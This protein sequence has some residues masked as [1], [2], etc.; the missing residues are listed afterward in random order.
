MADLL[1]A[2]LCLPPRPLRNADDLRLPPGTCDSHLH[3]F[4]AGAPLASPRNYTPQIETLS[5]WLALAGSFG[6][7]RGVLVQPSVY[8]LDN[9]VLLTALTAEPGR[10]RG[11][12]VIAPDTGDAE[13]RRLDRLGVRGVRINLRNKAGLGL[14]AMAALAPCISKLGWHVQFQVGPDA[15]GTVAELCARHAIDGVIDHLAFMPLDPPGPALD[16]L[17]RALDGGRV[18]AKISAPYRLEDTAGHAGYR[19]ALAVLAARHPDRLLWG[20]DWPHTELF[21]SMPEDHA[22]VALSL[23][24]LPA[25]TH[26]RVFARNA[27]Q[28]YWSH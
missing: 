20:S 6:I 9:S 3:V 22:L 17:S 28:L 7:A 16:E 26:D 13:L 11:I 27:E 5:G 10:L 1:D 25:E 8:G 12:V 15:I 2:A 24:A 4:A 23:D 18:H 21:D 19:A 14:E